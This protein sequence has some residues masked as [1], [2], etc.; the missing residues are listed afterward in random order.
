MQPEHYAPVGEALIRALRRHCPAWD[1]EAEAAWTTA[2][3]A[4]ADAMIAG[5]SGHR[6]PAVWKGRVVRHERRTRVLAVLHV[7]TGEP[8]QWTAAQYVTVQTGKWQRVWRPYSIANAPGGDEDIIELHV[9]AVG[10]GWVSTAL[11]RDTGPDD[12]IVIGPPVGT[13]T[14]DTIGDRDLVLVAGGTG[15]A[16]LKAIVQHVLAADEEAVAGG[17][18]MRRRIC[19]FHGV[20]HPMDLY[21]APLLHS[22]QSAYP[23]F[24]AVPVVSDDPHFGG[25]RGDVADVA[26]GWGG[27]QDRDAFISG[28][29]DMVTGAVC[30]FREAGLPAPRVHFDDIEA[31]HQ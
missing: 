24:S 4:A 1:E 3:T 27:W 7:H 31:Q 23:W 5:A 14:P 2:Y 17:Y 19:L 26:L 28:P 8:M 30:G 29:L 15:L 21:D 10:G 12:E 18:G 13:M 9:R 25:P 6:G 11:V 20:R 22:L 16:P